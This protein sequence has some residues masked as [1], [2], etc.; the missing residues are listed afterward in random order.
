MH[1]R[2]ALE[3]RACGRAVSHR[4][5]ACLS[6]SLILSMVEGSWRMMTLREGHEG[7]FLDVLRG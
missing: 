3:R 4:G 1:R 2:R 6:M 7:L 5:L